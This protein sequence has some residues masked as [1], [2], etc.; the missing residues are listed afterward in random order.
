MIDCKL[1]NN[2]AFLENSSLSEMLINTLNVG[3]TQNMH[4]IN[5]LTI[6]VLC[7]FGTVKI[8]KKLVR[9][10]RGCNFCSVENLPTHHAT[11]PW[12]K[13]QPMI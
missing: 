10:G 11:E 6:P 7:W 4:L 12:T 5:K 9:V 13:H 8:V 2:V 1:K 3:A